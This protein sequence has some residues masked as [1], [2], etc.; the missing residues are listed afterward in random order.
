MNNEIKVSN[1]VKELRLLFEISRLFE[2]LTD[3]QAHLGEALSLMTRY[4]G[5]VRG[6]VALLNAGRQEI[7]LAAAVGLSPDE[8]ERAHY[9]MGEG[10]TGRVIETGQPMVTPN[11]SDEPLFLNRTG[12]RDLV[13][14]R[15]SFFCVPIKIGAKTI[16]ALSADRLFADSVNLDEDLRLLT[17]LAS[18]IAQAAKVRQDL[19][20]ERESILAENQCLKVALESGLKTPA[21]LGQS[22]GIKKVYSLIAQV[23]P[24]NLSVLIQGESGTGKELA[25]ETIHQ[26]SRRSSKPFI[27]VNC[28]ALP[29]HLVETE[30]FGHE[31]GAFTGAISRHKGRFEL[32][33]GGTLFLDE[34]GELPLQVQAKLL[35]VLQE[36]SFER[37]GGD[38]T[39]SVDARLVAATNRNLGQMVSEGHFREDLYYR[40]NVFAIILPP[41]RERAVDLALLAEHFLA[42]WGREVG[43]RI[44]GL[45]PEALSALKA[46]PWPGNIRE[47]S[48]V[49][50]RAV[51]L[52]EDGLVSIRHL[53][54]LSVEAELPPQVLTLT[55]ALDELEL[56]LITGALTEHH[57]NMSRAAETLG[58]S[59]RVIGLRMKKFNLDFK[60]FRKNLNK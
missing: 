52:C 28:A 59:E 5:M 33:D 36:K 41:L 51:I 46:W 1:E 42:Y 56:R 43:K 32:A 8:F 53:P 20:A 45:T 15:I 14:E 17:I 50:A 12:A 30:L 13:K 40:L 44:L 38:E 54:G 57:G 49:L 26:G 3:V 35:R 4:T 27:R 31:K 47:L 25:A 37:V 21:M 22:D 11:L 23:A 60:I 55:G 16:G 2:G 9:R 19:A 58:I 34:V 48:N 18:L 29:E 6:A 24:T 7:S 10:I 39:I